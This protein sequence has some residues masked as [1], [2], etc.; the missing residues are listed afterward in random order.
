MFNF[1][2]ALVMLRNISLDSIDTLDDACE[3]AHE[4]EFSEVNSVFKILAT[5]FVSDKTRKEVT[6][7]HLG[8][9]QGMQFTDDIGD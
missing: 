7:S 8:H 5:E 9:H 6:I 4:L 3:V 1:Y 2:K